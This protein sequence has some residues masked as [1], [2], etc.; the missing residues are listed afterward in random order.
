MFRTAIIFLCF[1]LKHL[2]P[3]HSEVY[4]TLYLFSSLSLSI[5][6]KTSQFLFSDQSADLFIYTIVHFLHAL[7]EVTFHTQSIFF[8]V[9]G[10]AKTKLRIAG[11]PSR[12]VHN[13]Y[14]DKASTWNK[15][16]HMCY[17]KVNTASAP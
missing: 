17:I 5:Y 10:G 3:S 7:S 4:P 1:N 6:L 12:F 15:S 8:S 16:S 2:L 9:H 11:K 14:F 13:K